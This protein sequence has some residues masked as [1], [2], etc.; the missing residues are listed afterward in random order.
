[1][2]DCAS[3]ISCGRGRV[4]RGIV[5]CAAGAGRSVACGFSGER[6]ARAPR[7]M[8]YAQRRHDGHLLR[9]IGRPRHVQPPRLET[10]EQAAHRRDAGG[11]PPTFGGDPERLSIEIAPPSGAAPGCRSHQAAGAAPSTAHSHRQVA[12]QCPCFIAL[13]Q[14]ADHVQIARR[15]SEQNRDHLSWPCRR[16][17][18]TRL[19]HR[20]RRALADPNRRPG[21]GFRRWRIGPRKL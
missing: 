12:R 1:M 15:T 21:R 3:L 11:R 14:R 7:A 4:Y 2:Q 10:Q 6:I 19:G 20:R 9:R 13:E 8:S 17:H 16:G 5:R 18:L